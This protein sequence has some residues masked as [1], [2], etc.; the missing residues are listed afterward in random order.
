MPPNRSPVV[1]IALLGA[2][3]NMFA[4]AATD[5]VRTLATPEAELPHQFTGISGL[6][7]LSDGRVIVV[8]AGEKL[9]A[10]VNLTRRTVTRI[11]REG[12]G[13]GPPP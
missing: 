9:V 12:A 8:D 7:E 6:H 10:L 3:A 4:Q 5:S 11:G 1:A 2:T 13:A